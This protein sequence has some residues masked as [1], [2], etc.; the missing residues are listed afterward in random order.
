M[1]RIERH[2]SFGG[3]QDVYQHE[4]SSLG[5]TMKFGVYLPPQASSGPVPVLYWLSGLT[6]TE[7]NFITKS[8][9]QQLAAEH[10]IA[11]VAPDTS[12]RGE[13]VADDPAYDLGQ[14]AGFYV[15]ATE[16]PWSDHYRMYDYVVSELPALVEKNF[17]VSQARSISGHSMGGH[18]ALVIALRNPGRY[19][20]VSAFSP[21][22]APTQAPWGQKAFSAYLGGDQEQW[23]QYDAVEL[24]ADA[25]ERLP[26]L[27]DQGLSDDF[28]QNQ[29][30]P[31]LLQDACAKVNHP[32]S[33]NLRD[34]YDHSYYFISSFIADHLKHHASALNT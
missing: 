6:C 4:S 21:I 2:A 1:E 34:G 14:G 18:G 10:G 16:A 13:S 25:K 28:L 5:C 26:L 15:N 8:A 20:S 12:P 19:R 3:W 23:R 24:I 29:L 9:V 30:R 33:L 32:L 27:V 7:Q 31:E 17:P 22:V 11:I